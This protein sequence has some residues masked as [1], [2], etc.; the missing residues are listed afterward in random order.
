MGRCRHWAGR[1]H[2][3]M[4]PLLPGPRRADQAVHAGAG[5]LPLPGLHPVKDRRPGEADG[6]RL[7]DREDSVLPF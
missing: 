7:V 5:G 3:R 4:Q 6:S 2:E 1:Q